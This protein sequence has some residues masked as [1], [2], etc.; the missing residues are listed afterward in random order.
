MKKYKIT[1][2]N[3]K[4]IFIFALLP[5]IAALIIVL[6][7][8]NS[9]MPQEIKEPAVESGIEVVV[10]IIEGSN[11]TQIANL[12]EEKGVVDDSFTFRLY[13][14][15]QGKEKNLLPGSYKLLTGSKYE[16]VLSTITTGE[17]QVIYKLVIPE[18][19]TVN[20][21]K[22]RII[23]DIPFVEQ[24]EL[25]EAMDINNFSGYEFIK[26]KEN[27]EGFLFPKTYD[28]ILEYNAVNILEMMIAQYQVETNSLDWSYAD[29]NNFEYYDILKIASLIE[30]EAYIPE[31]RPL[32]SAV[33][34]N[35]LRTDKTNKLLQID[36]TIQY[37]LGKPG[38]W[39]PTINISDYE[40]DSLYNTYINPG[41]PPTPICNPGL[42]AIKAALEPADVDYLYYVVVNEET[43]EHKFSNTFEEHVNA[44]NQ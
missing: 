37:A 15:Q 2:D 1:L 9:I 27:L 23:K 17:K 26:E 29:N 34:Y 14:Q 38:D 11:L 3:L 31:E 12:L 8:C 5:A 33:I 39:W 6:P 18:G 19:F 30:R 22:D 10:E 16:D 32:I 42:A 25:E 41:L 24:Q 35:R 44:T 4:S 28:V 13:V 36:A 21:V 40:L 20:Q 43:H 7:S